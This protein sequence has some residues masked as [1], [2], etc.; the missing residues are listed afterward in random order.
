MTT[1]GELQD[2]PLRELR[3][4]PRAHLD[5]KSIAIY[6]GI[7]CGVPRVAAETIARIDKPLGRVR[8]FPDS[9]GRFRDSLLARKE[10]RTA[11]AHPYT[12]YYTFDESTITVYRILHQRQYLD[13]YAF[14][15]W[16]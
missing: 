11:C 7:E 13:D 10:Y 3:W 4:R 5:R 1:S 14:M 12:I 8:L 2:M 15:E 9:G 16:E 6:L